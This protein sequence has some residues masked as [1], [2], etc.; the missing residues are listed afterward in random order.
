MR[1]RGRLRATVPAALLLLLSALGGSAAA[2]PP[3]ATTAPVGHFI[4]AYGSDHEQVWNDPAQAAR[5][6]QYISLNPGGAHRIDDFRAGNP[7]TP[8]YVYNDPFFIMDTGGAN[9]HPSSVCA[10]EV[11]ARE[12][13]YAHGYNRR[14]LPSQGWPY[15][16]VANILNRGARDHCVKHLAEQRAN[17]FDGFFIDNTNASLSGHTDAGDVREFPS[18]QAYQDATGEHLTELRS[19]VGLP[20]IG[21]LGGVGAWNNELYAGRYQEP[22]DGGFLEHFGTWASNREYQDPEAVRANLDLVERLEARADTKVWLMTHVD[23]GADEVKARYG[24][25]LALLV[26]E[27]DTYYYAQPTGADAVDGIWLPEFDYDVGRPQGARVDDGGDVLRRS[28]E[29][30]EVWVNMATHETAIDMRAGCTPGQEEPPPPEPELRCTSV[31]WRDAPG[32][33][34][35]CLGQAENDATDHCR[36]VRRRIECYGNGHGIWDRFVTEG[37]TRSVRIRARGTNCEG[38]PAM[39]VWALDEWREFRLTTDWREY[40]LPLSSPKGSGA[41]DYWIELGEDHWDGTSACDRNLHVDWVAL[42]GAG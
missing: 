39:R 32:A 12:D 8:I 28:F 31:H 26:G 15:V 41:H 34:R 24:Y 35:E 20:M 37:T 25:A 33:L 38:T 17:G 16:F 13:W 19:R 29:C 30:A 2:H 4:N 21:N 18:D 10:T 11:E 40:V 23:N 1:E 9:W 22:L 27:G 6:H 42:D 5:R 3:S 36:P 7:N 14:R